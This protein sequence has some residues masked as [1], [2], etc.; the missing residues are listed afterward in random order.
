[1]ADRGFFIVFVNTYAGRALFFARLDAL[2]KS[3]LSAFSAVWAC[4][5]IVDRRWLMVG[6]EN[7]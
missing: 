6:G 4:R 3:A 1:M 2:F 5:L 7:H